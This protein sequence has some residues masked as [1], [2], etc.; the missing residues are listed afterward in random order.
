MSKKLRFVEEGDANKY[1][2]LAEDNHW[3][4]AIQMNG[5]IVLSE[6]RKFMEFVCAKINEINETL[7]EESEK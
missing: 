2:I 4:C 6:Q 1:M 3:I 5:S 7:E